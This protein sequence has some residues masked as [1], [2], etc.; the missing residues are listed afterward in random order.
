MQYR[1]STFAFVRELEQVTSRGMPV[2][3]RGKP[4]RELLART[5]SLEKPLERFVIVPGRR[6]DPFATIAETMW[7]IAGRDDIGFLSRYLGRA[8]D[9]S[10]DGMVWRGGYGP[11]LR[12]WQGVDQVNEIRKL[13]LEDPESRRAVAVMF[14]P[15][16]DFDNSS[17]DVPCNNWLHFMVRDGR[18]DL[19]I[20]IRSNDILWGFSGI[21]TFEWSVLHE[22]MSHW[23]KA[24]VGYA[25]FFI[26]SLHLYD[27]YEDRANA[28]LKGFDER[29]GYESGWAPSTFSTS[30]DAFSSVTDR[31]FEIEAGLAAGEDR[32]AAI[33]AFPDLLL[34]D[35]LRALRIKWEFAH[36]ADEKSIRAMVADLG[37]VDV[38]LAIQEW[39]FKDSRSFLLAST[40]PIDESGLQRT[41]VDLHRSKDASYGNS[42]KRRGEQVSIL[43]NIARKADRIDNVTGGS[44]TGKESLL[45]TAA[46]LF[47]YAMKYETFLAD[48]DVTAGHEI[49]GRAGTGFS[50]GPEGFE[51]LLGRRG[52]SLEFGEIVDEAN[53]VAAQFDALDKLVRTGDPSVLEKASAARALTDSA[54]CLLLAVASRTTNP[55][56]ILRNEIG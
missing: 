18:L 49:F 32:V 46:D 44:P 1:N 38:A 43:A 4:T 25:N 12:N 22:L 14:D 50:D 27:E 15:A 13:L 39:L 19:D 51:E 24:K 41:I 3:V 26:S 36:G 56:E 28:C 29:S 31:W 6:N 48:E 5:V 42:W 21:N 54:T 53:A 17:R 23:L 35:F 8:G 45:D 7:V 9:F 40:D 30:W 11:R 16:R 47:V 2:I 55:L 20:V 34:R 10:D 33:E 52:F 37:R